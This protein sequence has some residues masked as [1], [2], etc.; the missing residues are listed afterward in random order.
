[1]KK[2][3]TMSLA[4]LV[5]SIFLSSCDTDGD[6]MDT[7]YTSY[8]INV[9]YPEYFSDQANLEVSF[10]GDNLFDVMYPGR[11]PKTGSLHI[12]YQDYMPLD[13]TVT[14]QPG[15][16]LQLLLLP[17]KLIELYKEEEY[18]SFTGSF[19]MD[20]YVAKLNGQELAAGLN[21]INKRKATGNL[22]IYEVGGEIP[23]ATIPV[24]IEDGANLNIMKMGESFVEVP[25]DDEPDPTSNKILKAHFLY[26]GDETLT[27]D[28][29][30]M[31]FYI[32]DDWCWVF[33]PECVGSIT[34]E[35][36]KFSEYIELDC[37]FREPDAYGTCMDGAY[38][39]SFYYDVIDPVTGEILIDHNNYSSGL[40]INNYPSTDWMTWSYKKATFILKDG[41]NS[42]DFESALSTPWE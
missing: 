40:G 42:C 33:L 29:I 28:V 10:N 21:Y 32:N 39:Y 17:G 25:V 38:G 16:T 36:G 31:D 9:I 27:Q 18:I 20:G 19:I 35:K 34:L 23:V 37:S 14:L 7:G 22:E 6:V 3:F 11:E 26:Q 5:I 41:G 8:S 12:E 2:V 4:L 15:E 13:T 30:R 1:M 24:N